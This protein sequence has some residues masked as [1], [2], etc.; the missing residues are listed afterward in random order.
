MNSQCRSLKNVITELRKENAK[1]TVAHTTSV[2]A[3]KE[4]EEEDSYEAVCV[5]TTETV[6]HYQYNPLCEDLVL[7]DYCASASIFGNKNLLTNIRP[8]GT[9]TFTGIGGSIDVNQQGDFGVFGTVAYD[10]R[11]TFNV[12][13]VDSLPESSIVTY[14]HA[15]R[16]HT[17]SINHK[18]YDF[19]VPHG[20]EG[21]PVRRFPHVEQPSTS[22][23]FV[24][25]VAQNESMYTK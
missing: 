21:L 11:A 17:I 9:I 16:C 3:S 20:K 24:N 1:K 14:N 12:L 5:H 7:C 13:S 6:L 4:V 18:T 23:I 15:D 8:S 22:H 2:P 19:K 10:E 25:K